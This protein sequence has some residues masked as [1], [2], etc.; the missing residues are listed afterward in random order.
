MVIVAIEQTVPKPQRL[1]EDYLAV[2]L[3]PERG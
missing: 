1:V 3:L 2:R